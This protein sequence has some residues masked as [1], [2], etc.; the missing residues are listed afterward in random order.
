MCGTH[1][2]KLDGDTLELKLANEFFP[3]E[4]FANIGYHAM[5]NGQKTYNGVAMV[6][7]I[8]CT[9]V[10]HDNP[11]LID[12]QKR[13]ICANVGGVRLINIYAVNGEALGSDNIKSTG[14]KRLSK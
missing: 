5:V 6:S 11:H 10:I 3:Y 9:E 4:A 14:I 8:S 2:A 1:C 13:M 12:P 7:K